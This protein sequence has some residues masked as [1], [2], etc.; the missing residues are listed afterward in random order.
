MA[1][2]YINNSFTTNTYIIIIKSLREGKW[3]KEN[4]DYCD[5]QIEFCCGYCQ[6]TLSDCTR[7]Y[8]LQD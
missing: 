5:W 3:S 8:M 2:E 1:F 4:W 6:T 7:V